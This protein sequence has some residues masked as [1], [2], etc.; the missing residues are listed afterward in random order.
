MAN[1]NPLVPSSIKTARGRTAGST[2]PHAT[3]V[4]VGDA[5]NCTVKFPKN[6]PY[7]S[8]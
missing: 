7:P 3:S 4:S 8:W 1:L 6:L 5:T 2:E